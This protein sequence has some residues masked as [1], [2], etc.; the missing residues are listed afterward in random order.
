MAVIDNYK[1]LNALLSSPA[2]RTAKHSLFMKEIKLFGKDGIG[3]VALVDDEDFKELNKFRWHAELD[4]NTLYVIRGCKIKGK[5]INYRMHRVIMN[6][7]KRV[8]SRS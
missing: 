2:R 4:G 1:T 7:P 8:G 5:S 6:C 3:K